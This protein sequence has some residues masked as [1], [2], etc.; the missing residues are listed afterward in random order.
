MLLIEPKRVIEGHIRS[1]H[2]QI[3]ALIL[4]IFTPLVT[5][6]NSLSYSEEYTEC[7]KCHK[8]DSNLKGKFVHPAVQMGCA[9]CHSNAHKKDAKDPLGLALDD[10]P[11]LCFNCHDSK[12]FEGKVIHPP[13]ASGTCT[14][15]H[16]PHSSNTEKLLTSPVPQLCYN[17]H[18]KFDRKIVHAPVAAGLC[19]LCHTPHA[20]SNESL[21]LKPL[22]DICIECHPQVPKM[23]HVIAR[24]HPLFFKNDPIRKGKEFTCVSCHNPHDSDSMLLFR[25]KVEGGDKYLLCEHCHKK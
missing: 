11:Q 8:T 5:L 3:L 17:C 16:N 10:V 9:V 2:K 1:M 22:N 13:A 4:I 19:L 18:Q 12:M 20:G 25:Y 14:F 24:G 6:W 15:C 21:L 23:E 7:T